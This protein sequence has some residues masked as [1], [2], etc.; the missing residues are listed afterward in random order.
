MIRPL[1]KTTAS[2]L[3]AGRLRYSIPT[4]QGKALYLTFDDGPHP[5]QT[6]AILDILAEHDALASFFLSGTAVEK[7]PTLVTRILAAGHAL[8]NHGYLHQRPD[9]IGRKAYLAGIT[10]TQLLLED[11]AG[12]PLPRLF[13]PPFGTLSLSTMPGILARGYRIIMWNHDSMDSFIR[14]DEQLLSIA[15]CKF[16]H[17]DSVIIL[18]HDD[19][20]QTVNLL[21]QLL[22]FA[23]AHD[24]PLKSLT[25]QPGR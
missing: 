12:A 11:I 7:T 19:Q 2:L 15:A 24:Y 6:P 3:L 20:P 23:A 22:S 17:L 1:I 5:D 10:R 25:G 8:G 21:P 4:G 16:T 14:D 9:A 18:C 13:R